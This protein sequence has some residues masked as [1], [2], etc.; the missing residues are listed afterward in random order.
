MILQLPLI[1]T[2]GYKSSRQQ[3]H[4]VSPKVARMS[5]LPRWHPD[6]PLEFCPCC[7]SSII[8]PVYQPT[9][10]FHASSST[11]A[12]LMTGYVTTSTIRKYMRATQPASL[13]RDHSAPA[14]FVMRHSTGAYRVSCSGMRGR[15]KA[16]RCTRRSRHLDKLSVFYR[17]TVRLRGC[18]AV[19]VF[20]HGNQPAWAAF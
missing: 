16:T 1:L 7:C 19:N 17:E 10:I 6:H 13:Q 2:L 4:L 18:H 15:N 12:H 3:D 14:H 5:E 9:A 8:P 20:N 11:N